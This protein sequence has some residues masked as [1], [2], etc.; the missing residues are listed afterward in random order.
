[1]HR[2]FLSNSSTAAPVP[3]ADCTLGVELKLVS[4]FD[5]AYTICPSAALTSKDVSEGGGISTVTTTSI[6]DVFEIVVTTELVS[7]SCDCLMAGGG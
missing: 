4:Y 7:Q 6:T 5:A 3:G 2:H 1:M